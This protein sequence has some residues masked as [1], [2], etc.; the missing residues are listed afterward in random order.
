MSR[1]A[2]LH[3]YDARN[4]ANEIYNSNQTG[5]RD[6][7]SGAVKFAVPTVADGKVFEGTQ[8][9]L[10]VYGLFEEA[11]RLPAARTS[12]TAAPLSYTEI[13]LSWVNTDRVHTGTRI[14]RSTD[15]KNYTLA[16]TRMI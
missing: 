15:G 14:L 12:L 13:K 1:P 16:N 4:L 8:T 3:A 11:T 6:Q 9:N 10:A 5:L 2:V 7:P